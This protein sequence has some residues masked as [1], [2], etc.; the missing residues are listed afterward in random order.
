MKQFSLLFSEA[1]RRIAASGIPI[2]SRSQTEPSISRELNIRRTMPT[3]DRVP[4]RTIRP[5]ALPPTQPR[6]PISQLPRIQRRV[7]A[8]PARPR[9]RAPRPPTIIR[10]S[11]STSS[12]NPSFIDNLLNSQ[13]RLHNLQNVRMHG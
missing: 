5:P 8:P 3:L 7:D 2:L 6:T 12:T 9:P 11:N 10:T 1:A 4:S 13:E